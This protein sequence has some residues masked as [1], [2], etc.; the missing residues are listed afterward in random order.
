[1]RAEN[2]VCTTLQFIVY[3]RQPAGLRYFRWRLLVLC[4]VTTSTEQN[5]MGCK[6]RTK[7]AIGLHGAVWV[8][9]ARNTLDLLHI[10]F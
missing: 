6:L 4:D 10:L 1:M 8:G 3:T 5:C 9:I 2:L 7:A